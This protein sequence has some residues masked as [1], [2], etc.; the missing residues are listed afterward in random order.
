MH[1][2]NHIANRNYTAPERFSWLLLVISFAY[3]AFSI[4]FKQLDR[5]LND[6]FVLTLETNY[7]T[8]SYNLPALTICT[9]YQNERFIA[10][11]YKYTTNVSIDY[12][13]K[14]YQDYHYDMKILGSITADSMHIIDEFKNTT[15]L[16][17]LSGEEL[18]DVVTYLKASSPFNDILRATL[19]PTITEAGIC[20]EFSEIQKYFLTNF[21]RKW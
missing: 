21:T 8:W 13:S 19:T 12:Y 17:N 1:G 18:L 7:H 10:A 5:F 9:D 2:F 16:Q 4:C 11:F 6:P 20:N 3:F 15:S 14:S